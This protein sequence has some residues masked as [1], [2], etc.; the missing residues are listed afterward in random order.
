MG[1]HFAYSRLSIICGAASPNAF[2]ALSCK[3][4]RK[5]GSFW[6]SGWSINLLNR[7]FAEALDLGSTY[8]LRKTI[9][10]SSSVVVG[11]RCMFLKAFNAS[12]LRWAWKWL[13]FISTVRCGCILSV[14]WKR[15]SKYSNSS[16]FWSLPLKVSV[17][18]RWKIE[19][20]GFFLQVSQLLGQSGLQDLMFQDARDEIICVWSNCICGVWILG[21]LP[22]DDLG[23]SCHHVIIGFL[24]VFVYY[25]C[26]I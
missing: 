26:I 23:R 9:K 15:S 25:D 20:S 2:S 14:V 12:P 21:T 7:C 1:R 6:F 5:S 24:S 18:F 11:V 13:I 4:S 19:G 8:F 17:V 22:Q 3:S 10:M 16:F